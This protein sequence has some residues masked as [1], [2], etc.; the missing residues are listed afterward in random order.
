MASP[1]EILDGTATVPENVVYREFEAETLLLNLN[2]G[3]YHGLNPTGGRLLQLLEE[4]DGNVRAAIT[5][6]AAEYE[7]AEDD[8]TTDM[9]DFCAALAERGLIEVEDDSSG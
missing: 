4:T 3:Q 8:I 1:E 7:V 5:K 9:A 2:T 6:L